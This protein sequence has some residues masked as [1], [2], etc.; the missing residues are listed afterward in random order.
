MAVQSIL[1]WL[2][3][4]TLQVWILTTYTWGIS[5]GQGK[6]QETMLPT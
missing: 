4:C 6:D 3:S 2:Y 1:S 5:E